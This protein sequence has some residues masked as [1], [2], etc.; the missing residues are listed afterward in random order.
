MSGTFGPITTKEFCSFERPENIKLFAAESNIPEHQNPQHTGLPILGA[1]AK[2]RKA[3]LASCLPV[4]M[5]QL[6]SH[7]PDFQAV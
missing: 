5:E 4:R 3:T 7:R 1:F 2:F 6:G